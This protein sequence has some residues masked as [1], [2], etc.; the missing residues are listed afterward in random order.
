MNLPIAFL[1]R[2]K[3]RMGTEFE[4][5]LASYEGPIYTGLRVNTL[6]IS[7]KAFLEIF[8]YPLEP[9]PWTEDGF[10]YRE[11][12]PVTKHPLFYAG[13]YYIQEPSAMSPVTVLRP[14][15]GDRVLD[16]CAAPGGKTLQIASYT[17]DS[18][19]L[20]TNDINDKRVKAIVRNVEKYG[21]KNVLVLNEDQHAIAKALPHFFDRILIDAPCSGEGMFKKDHKAVKAWE[22]Y[23]NE[24]CA[25]MQRDILE[26]VPKLVKENTKLV[27]STC[28]FSEVENEAQLLFLEAIDQGFKKQAIDSDFFDVTDGVAHLWPHLLKGEGHFIGAMLYQGEEDHEVSIETSENEVTFKNPIQDGKMKSDKIKRSPNSIGDIM[29]NAL[30]AF[31]VFSD[32]YLNKS[33]QG[34]FSIERDKIYL[35]PEQ[36]VKVK[37]LHVARYGWLLGEIKR[38]KFIPSQAFAMGICRTDFKNVIDMPAA[39]VQVLKFLKG[40]TLD[41]DAVTE[42]GPLSK[43]FCLFCTDGYPLGFVKVEENLIKNLYP[44]SWRMM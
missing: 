27:Y 24:T 7:V 43:G 13:L 2:M 39:S 30:D 18:G 14:E 12:D 37:A 25:K 20:V 41:Y 8:P 23:A 22:A 3:I 29:N 6:K 15:C 36:Q 31:K 10:Y 28:T 40:E 35:L 26:V 4:A 11:E 5:F 9:V 38:D 34:T 32:Q 17:Q 42:A 33:I 16:L 19:L 1:E 21:V 44:I